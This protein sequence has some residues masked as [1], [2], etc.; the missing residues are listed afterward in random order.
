MTRDCSS[1]S[2]CKTCQRKHNTLLHP[3]KAD[4]R[5]TVPIHQNTALHQST[6]QFDP[7]IIP[8]IVSDGSILKCRALLDSGAELSMM[9]EDCAQRLQLKRTPAA[10][11]LNGIVSSQNICSS[12]V[13]SKTPCF[14]FRCKG[15]CNAK[16][17]SIPSNSFLQSENQSFQSR[18]INPADPEFMESRQIDLNLGPDVNEHIVLDEKLSKDNGLHLRNTILGWVV[19][20]KIWEH[21]NHVHTVTVLKTDIDLKHFWEL[22]EVELPQKM[23]EEFQ[24]EQHFIDT[25]KQAEDRRFIVKLAFKQTPWIGRQLFSS[26]TPILA[27]RT[28]TDSKSSTT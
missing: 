9:T 26:K 15:F 18:S 6:S 13:I 24:C 4:T 28:S 12:I 11:R 20:G 19:S 7:A 14:N 22:E 3:E 16:L 25:T 5:K 8:V 1:K 23:T 27:T 17:I 2:L 10:L 21:T